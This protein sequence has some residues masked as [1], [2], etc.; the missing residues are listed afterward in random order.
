MGR[1]FFGILLILL[2]VGFLLDQ[3]SIIEFNNIISTYWPSMIILLG[4]SGLLEKRS[5]KFWNSIVILV[6]ALLQLNRLG[7]LEY[8]AFRLFWP[9]ILILVG[10]NIIF[11]GGKTHSNYRNDS[12]DDNDNMDS[13]QEYDSTK[14]NNVNHKKEKKKWTTNNLSFEDTINHFIILSGLESNN[15]SQDFK[16]GRLSTI[17]G[18]IELDLRGAKL[19]ENEVYLETNAFLGGIEVHV[20]DHWRVEVSGTPLL[21]G[22]SNNTRPNSDPDAPIL[23]VRYLAI[24][25]GIEIN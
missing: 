11:S 20:P 24:L 1:Y 22:M 7:Y 21:G 12:Y 23:R 25:G 18:S 13:N 2:G 15:Q 3:A 17:L 19:Y 16:G 14:E 6:G 10:I 5:N 9:I 8:N 4:I